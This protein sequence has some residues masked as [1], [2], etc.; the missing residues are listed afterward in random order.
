MVSN[1][2]VVVA[3]VLSNSQV[4]PNSIEFPLAYENILPLQKTFVSLARFFSQT[5]NMYMI[6]YLS[7]LSSG[8]KDFVSL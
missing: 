8:E 2:V 4:I 7:Y 5:T 3:F 1:F 6:F